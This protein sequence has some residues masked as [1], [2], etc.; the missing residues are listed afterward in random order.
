MGSTV[1]D[2]GVT[3]PSNTGVNTAVLPANTTEHSPTP[4]SFASAFG[5]QLLHKYLCALSLG[6]QEE[7]TWVGGGAIRRNGFMTEVDCRKAG[8]KIA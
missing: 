5:L 6:T 3:P 2:F 1:K 7:F 8:I 4:K